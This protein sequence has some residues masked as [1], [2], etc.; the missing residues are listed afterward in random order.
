MTRLRFKS[1]SNILV[2]GLLVCRV[3]LEAIGFTKIRVVLS[4]AL[5]MNYSN[6][7]LSCE[8]YLTEKHSSKGILIFEM[9]TLKAI[10]F[11]PNN[12]RN[13]PRVTCHPLTL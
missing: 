6:K 10:I 9:P 4:F 8:L 13:I 7:C 1:K 12:G 5:H 2:F 11:F 3:K